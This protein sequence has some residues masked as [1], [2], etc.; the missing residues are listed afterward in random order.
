MSGESDGYIVTLAREIE[1]G[2]RLHVGAN[3][4][5]VALAALLARRLW[6][7]RLMAVI[8]TD[9]VLQHRSSD[10]QLGRRCYD[11]RLVA[12]RHATFH[13][14]AAFDD[15]RRAPM[16]FA[17]GLQVDA[18]GNANLIGTRNQGR[19]SLRGPGSAGLPTMTTMAARFVIACPRHRP[20]TL[21]PRVDAISVLGDPAARRRSGLDPGSLAAVITPLARFEP[22][23]EG[24][25]LTELAVDAELAEVERQT[26]FEIRVEGEPARRAP[27]GEEEAALLDELRG[28]AR[29]ARA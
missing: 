7:P 20:A 4:P 26:G 24:L 11:P 1:D 10:V 6:A 25:V 3:Q 9:Y 12:E 16:M 17:G 22:S 27:V 18:R 19:Y 13:Q 2:T 15:L 5:D 21:V 14:S 28:A 29:R 23:E 8:A